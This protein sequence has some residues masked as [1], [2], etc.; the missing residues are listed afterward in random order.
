[1]K[2][3]IDNGHGAETAGK[4]S[5]DNRL[6]EWAYTRRLAR[7]TAK[8]L[9]ARGIENELLVPETA[10]VP[11][12]ERCERANAMSAGRADCVLVSVHVNA[13]GSEGWHTA[14]GWSAFVA[15]EA[16]EASRHLARKLTEQSQL[17]GLGGNRWLPPRGYWT[18]PLAICRG[19]RCPAVL[20]E[21]LFMDNKDDLEYL[22]GAGAVDELA[23]LHAD[24]LEAYMSRR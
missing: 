4:R 14:R 11:L 6:R 15:P 13:A 16:S 3:L 20:T 1:M 17:R 8:R 21:N 24:A 18:A 2:V 7:A 9:T 22:L 5:P 19:T 23:G 10:D 12:R